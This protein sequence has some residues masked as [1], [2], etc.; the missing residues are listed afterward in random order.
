MGQTGP[1]AGSRAVVTVLPSL[2]GEEV[3]NRRLINWTKQVL[4]G[5]GQ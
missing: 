3:L 4:K 1:A 2:D 5:R